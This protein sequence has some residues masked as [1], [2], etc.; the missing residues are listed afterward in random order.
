MPKRIVPNVGQRFDRLVYVGPIDDPSKG[1]F[2]CDCGSVAEIDLGHARR[3]H[4]RSCGCYQRERASAA[5]ST[6]RDVGTA[7]YRAWVNMKT[8]CTNPNYYLFADYGGRGI[9]VCV[10]WRDSFETFLADM[11]RRP[12]DQHYLDRIDPN[13]NYEPTNCR[14]AELLTHAR[15][16]RSVRQ[17]TIGERTLT[18]PEWSAVSG[19]RK[20]TI[21]RRLKKDGWD[22]C[23]AVFLPPA[24]RIPYGDREM[25]KI[26]N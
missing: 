24:A 25:A 26:P 2:R 19:V 4:T 21:W 16:K 7:E 6:H 14:W 9:S 8:R 22:P 20:K 5:T 15:N 11:G 18:I 23:D 13:G 1:L 10:A 3:R 12:T 17:I